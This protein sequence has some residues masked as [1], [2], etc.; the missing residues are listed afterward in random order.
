MKREEEKSGFFG[1]FSKLF[2]KDSGIIKKK[3]LEYKPPKYKPRKTNKRMA[4]YESAMLDCC[5]DAEPDF[6]ENLIMD[7]NDIKKDV[8]NFDELILNQDILEG[9][10]EKDEQSE[11]LMEQ[12]KDIYE[13]IKKYSEDKNINDE[14]VNITLLVLFYIYNKKNDKVNELKFIIDKAKK[15]VKKI[16]NLEYETIIKEIEAK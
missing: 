5:R 15:Y 3:N 11:I 4:C 13:K 16:F 2:S 12:E 8:L 1:F 10:W 9:N 6:H 7:I 14:N